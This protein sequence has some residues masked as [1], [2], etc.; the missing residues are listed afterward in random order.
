MPDKCKI[1]GGYAV[2]PHLHGREPGVNLDLCDVC[3]WRKHAK[4]RNDNT[5][6]LPGDENGLTKRETKPFPCKKCIKGSSRYDFLA[7]TRHLFCVEHQG[8]CQYTARTCKPLPEWKK[9]E[10]A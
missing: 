6:G 1:C 9:K 7:R 2:T 10:K 3:Y 8:W 4:E 5:S